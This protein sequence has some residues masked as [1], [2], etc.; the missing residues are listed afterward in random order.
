M[1]CVNVKY[2][3]HGKSCSFQDMNFEAS[4]VQSKFDINQILL[5]SPGCELKSCHTKN[6]KR[7]FRPR[8]HE[9]LWNRVNKEGFFGSLPMTRTSQSVHVE[10]GGQRHFAFTN[11]EIRTSSSQGKSNARR[12]I[13]PAATFFSWPKWS[14]LHIYL[15]PMNVQLSAWVQLERWW[16]VCLLLRCPSTWVLPGI[17]PTL[18]LLSFSSI[19]AFSHA[20]FQSSQC[21][22]RRA[23]VLQLLPCSCPKLSS[24]PPDI[25]SFW[26]HPATNSW[27][28]LPSA[29]LKAAP[30]I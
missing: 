5:P 8:E 15:F 21:H 20:D 1:Q 9:M 11:Y 18:M 10:R 16:Q 12:Q 28:C 23:A 17:S 3:N 30:C 24:L 22:E 26:F 6:K 29:N 4:E 7:R 25:A 13:L 27:L 2:P 14:Y 19:S